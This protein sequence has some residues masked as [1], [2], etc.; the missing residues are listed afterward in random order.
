M[1]VQILDGSD[2][3]VEARLGALDKVTMASLSK[4]LCFQFAACLWPQRDAD[5][6]SHQAGT[7]LLKGK[8]TYVAI[9]DTGKLPYLDEIGL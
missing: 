5:L 6:F 7:A 3:S 2:V 8:T 9:G 4:V 1:P